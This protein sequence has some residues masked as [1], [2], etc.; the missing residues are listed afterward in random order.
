MKERD[1]KLLTNIAVC[2]ACLSLI[3]SSGCIF[4]LI[5][6][7][8]EGEKVV[9]YLINEEQICQ[10]ASFSIEDKGEVYEV[11]TK[12]Y[13]LLIYKE[14]F[15]F[16]VLNCKE[17]VLSTSH[18]TQEIPY[19]ASSFARKEKGLTK[20]YRLTKILDFSL[21]PKLTFSIDTTLKGLT[22]IYTF[23]LFNG[24]FKVEWYLADRS[25]NKE[26]GDSFKIGEGYW[27]G[28]D[29]E[30]ESFPLNHPLNP[31]SFKKFFWCGS[32]ST[33]L[34][35]N[36][37][38]FGLWI[39]SSE[40]SYAFNYQNNGV[41][42]LKQLNS[43]KVSY[44]IFPSSDIVEA[45]L[46]A[47]TLAG[48][49]AQAPS[50]EVFEKGIWTTWAEYKKEIEQA[51]LID[52][53]YNIYEKG[54]PCW[55]IEIDDRWAPK[56][57][58]QEFDFEKFP[59]P[60][61]LTR[62]LEELGYKVTLWE[63]PWVNLDSSLYQEGVE[64]NYFL[65]TKKAKPAIIEW[66]DGKAAVIDL[67]NPLAWNWFEGNLRNLQVKYG[68]YGFKFDG[69]DPWRI[70]EDFKSNRE[71]SRNEYQILYS[72]FAAQFPASELRVTWLDQFLGNI[73]RQC[74]KESCWE[75]P[76]GLQQIIPSGLQTSL[77]GYP[78]GMP[79]MIGGNEYANQYKSGKEGEE[80]FL[81]WAEANALMPIMQFSIVPWRFSEKTQ[82]ICLKYAKLHESLGEYI[83]SLAKD[84]QKT[85]MPIMRPLF[86]L[87]PED[88]QTYLIEDE[89]VLGTKYLVAPVL[90]KGKV[91]RD[92]YLP[93]GKWK[94]Y[95]SDKEWNGPCWLRNYPAELDTLP[96][97]IYNGK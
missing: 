91:E 44:F 13:G 81:R 96:L 56:Y 70:P 31:C 73:V 86:F 72:K 10:P 57:G 94:D 53:A 8:K 42:G 66:W 36:S 28:G 26:I 55:I 68:I 65:K 37:K 34:W 77:N 6:E 54:F 45:Y 33:P 95:W 32:G 84:S 51:K 39:N 88:E 93:P 87:T 47:I 61:K 76:Y 92:I 14:N 41:I 60:K 1:K 62:E 19:S 12:E 35:L 30:P 97:F 48:K 24:Y 40:L 15:G 85:G 3:I 82:E 5:G 50:K 49:P 2:L 17:N 22:A 90:E 64:H 75:K 23:T 58:D 89:F 52:F 16:K 74:D 9:K 78:F 67:S 18:L 80:L 38:G 7:E 69:S 46:K 43:S 25:I 59:N 21:N 29:G 4:S 63:H 83:S 79:D 71:I 20:W 11:K 27:Y